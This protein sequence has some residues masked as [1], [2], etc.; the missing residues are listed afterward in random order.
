MSE[1]SGFSLALPATMDQLAA[2]PLCR[3]LQERIL[4]DK[5]LL[6]DGSAVERASTACLQIL[7][8]ASLSAA[9]RDIG[10]ELVAASPALIEALHDLGLNQLLPDGK[11]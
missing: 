10:F 4:R 6:I 7:L 9:A 1:P 5:K 3:A 8:A 2:E 11:Q